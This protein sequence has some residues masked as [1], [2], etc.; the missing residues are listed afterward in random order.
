MKA[1]LTKKVEQDL[2]R[3]MV[4]KGKTKRGNVIIGKGTNSLEKLLNRGPRGEAAQDAY[5]R[6][7]FADDCD[8]GW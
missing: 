7:F 6:D 1:K 3:G 4:L 8:D 5:D 2:E